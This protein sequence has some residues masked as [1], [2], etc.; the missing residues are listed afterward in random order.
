MNLEQMQ[1]MWQ[2]HSEKL[3]L[4]MSLNRNLLLE[5]QIQS[6]KSELNKLIVKRAI[7]GLLFFVTV[8]LLWKYIV[9]SW[10][11]S[12]PVVS[13]AILTF[14]AI[15]GLAGNIG[16]IVLLNKIDFS[17]PTKETM[18]DLIEVRSH[19]L[20]TF[21]LIMLSIPFYMAYVF[22]AYDIIFSVDLFSLMSFENKIGFAVVSVALGA[23]LVLFISKLKAENRG[24]KLIAWVFNEVSGESLTHL[25]NEIDNMAEDH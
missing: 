25:F 10:S 22:L 21:K 13:A 24:N 15:V 7:E 19:N 23:L 20:K 16:Q 4:C 17:K 2:E 9:S 5:K 11:V 6:Q 1:T 3:E 8:V 14:F 18:N 12:A